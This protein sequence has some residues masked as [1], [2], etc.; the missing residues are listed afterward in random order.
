MMRRL[1]FVI[2]FVI[3][4]TYSATLFS[5]DISWDG[6]G[7]ATSWS[8]AQNWSGDA[9]PGP[10]DH[11]IITLDGNYSIKLTAPVTIKGLTLGGTTGMQTLDATGFVLNLG[12]DSSVVSANG[13]LILGGVPGYNYNAMVIDGPLA[14]YGK[15][16]W[17]NGTIFANTY[18]QP[19]AGKQITI[20]KRGTMRWIGTGDRLIAVT[21]INYGKIY[22]EEANIYY[23]QG[24][25]IT[26]KDTFEIS[27]KGTI[28]FLRIGVNSQGPWI[29]TNTGT[30]LKTGPDS[31]RIE[32]DFQTTGGNVDVQQG[33]L[34]LMNSSR[35]ENASISV[36]ASA[37]LHLA[38][39]NYSRHTVVGSLTGNPAGTLLVSG[40]PSTGYYTT[41]LPDTT[42]N[43]I[44]D[45]GGTGIQ[46]AYAQIGDNSGPKPFGELINRGLMRFVGS[47]EHRIAAS[48]INEDTLSWEDGAIYYV[49]TGAFSNKGLFLMK[50]ISSNTFLTVGPNSSRPGP[51][52]NTGTVLKTDTSIVTSTVDF[53]TIGGIVDV[54]QGTLLQNWTSRWES[55][56]VSVSAGAV[57]QLGGR[58]NFEPHIIAGTLTG[59]PV[60]DFIV[61]G[62]PVTYSAHLFADSTGGALNIRGTGI[63]IGEAHLGANFANPYKYKA[64][65]NRGLMR[66]IGGR[67][68]H[69][70]G[71]FVNEDTLRWESATLFYDNT[72]SFTNNGYFEVNLNDDTQFNGPG[73]PLTNNGK[74]RKIDS[75][76]ATTN[77]SFQNN[78]QLEVVSGAIVY[79]YPGRLD[80][81][82]SGIISGSGYIDL[83]NILP[84]ALINDGITAPGPGNAGDGI[85]TLTIR[86][87]FPHNRMKFELAG[88]DSSEYDQLVLVQSTTPVDSTVAIVDLVYG[89][90]PVN[91]DFF[92][93]V[94]GTV[95]NRLQDVITQ[96][97]VNLVDTY[98]PNLIRLTFLEADPVDLTL[99]IGTDSAF[100]GD[101]VKIPIIL[102]NPSEASKRGIN[103]VTVQFSYNATLLEPILQTSGSNIVSGSR[104]TTI[105]FLVQSQTD[106]ILGF[107]DFRAG[108]GNAASTPLHIDTSFTNIPNPDIENIDGLFTLRGI[109][110]EG[111]TR[112][113]DPSGTLQLK[114][115]SN[116][117]DGNNIPITIKTIEKGRAKL[118]M[119]DISGKS[120]KVFFDNVLE[121]GEWELYINLS[122]IA[123]GRYLLTVKS[124][125]RQATVIMEVA[126]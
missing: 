56:N 66:F 28:S 107:A 27:P 82:T 61:K 12:T 32:T 72:A 118:Y 62:F 13:L 58:G 38:A 22:W 11:A 48:F 97:G 10:A 53:F 2:H 51:F 64:P 93:I 96:P 90:T 34:L 25:T 116:P 79:N 60:G 101:P 30:I 33:S 70:A 120:T 105:T 5:A 29:V 80:S 126:R 122:G 18:Y 50:P 95:T 43:N 103:S 81:Y 98:P 41:I 69:I 110:R 108:L 23:N 57:L 15:L 7:D 106:S 89:F 21:L 17:G 84:P 65:V 113:I 119:T 109:C 36:S 115:S 46:V 39:I 8:D 20:A 75:K 94:H 42:P 31:A 44:I 112:L 104:S 4:F 40:N 49:N 121:P 102:S 111:G 76:T 68:H 45:I 73:M 52:F 3:L 24:Y 74:I 9:L 86:G 67:E 47:L 114:L 37:L 85:G 88:T 125:T 83:Y 19:S 78:G 87:T 35:W 54:Q 100:A 71:E 92:D 117:A 91:G 14:V 59:S 124:E 99:R 6:E 123:N 55:A 1:L 26:N 16:D 63:Q 77:V